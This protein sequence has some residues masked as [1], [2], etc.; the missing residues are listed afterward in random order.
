MLQQVTISS[1]KDTLFTNFWDLY[2]SAF[3]QQERRDRAYQEKT[4]A[5]ENYHL[6]AFLSNDQFV[7]FIG[8]WQLDEICYIEHL[9][10]LPSLRGHGIGREALESFMANQSS[11]IILEV[12]HPEDE[13]SRRRIGFYQRVGFI[14]NN[15]QYEHPPYRLESDEP[16]SLIL[17]S[18]PNPITHTLFSS[19]KSLCFSEVHFIHHAN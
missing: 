4:L 12:E 8:W 9:A 19:F 10:T 7:G 2:V 18:Y 17:M 13:I 5:L 16:V 14:L 1:V 11:P 3:P 6:E 15:Y